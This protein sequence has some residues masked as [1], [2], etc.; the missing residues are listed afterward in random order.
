MQRHGFF[1]GMERRGDKAFLSFRAVGKLSHGDYQ[2]FMPLIENALSGVDSPEVLALM[3][4]REFDGWELQAAWDDFKLGLKHGNK[5]RKI[6]I[7]GDKYWIRHL[8]KISAWF[9]GGEVEFF[10]RVDSAL[11]WLVSP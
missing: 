8:A 2:Q 1:V 3:D 6:A 10:E 11:E 9:T 4:I 7:L 5:F